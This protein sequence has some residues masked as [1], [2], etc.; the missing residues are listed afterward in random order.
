MV[1]SPDPVAPL[2]NITYSFVI[3]NHGPLGA[4][5]VL[6]TQVLPANVTFVSIAASQGS[7]SRS[8][9]TLTCTLGSM[10]SNQTATVTT[11]VTAPALTTT[12][13]TTASVSSNE[14]DPTPADNQAQSSTVVQTVT[15]V[16]LTETSLPGTV[17][18]GESLTYQI[19]AGTVVRIR[20]TMLLSPGR[21]LDSVL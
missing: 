18:A 1:D 17:A 4:T 5:G 10:T 12:V 13:S 6:F 8:G 21:P 15:D 7:C 20:R 19:K 2:G 11:V 16:S 9:T 14:L 3:T